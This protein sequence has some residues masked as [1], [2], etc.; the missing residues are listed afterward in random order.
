MLRVLDQHAAPLRL[1][2]R[3]LGEEIERRSPTFIIAPQCETW[4]QSDP[5]T[6]RP[7]A[8]SSKARASGAV[9]AQGASANR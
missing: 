9:S 7:G 5:H 4:G 1:V 8:A 2:R 3:P 6:Q